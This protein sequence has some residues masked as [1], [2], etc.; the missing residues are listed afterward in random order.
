MAVVAQAVLDEARVLLNDLGGAVYPDL[1]MWPLINK[2]YRELQNKLTAY[3]V[4]TTK[5]VSTVVVVPANTVRLADGALL[6]AD[7][8]EPIELKE[9]ASGV[10]TARWV[11]V[12]PADFEP[13]NLSPKT[14]LGYW[15]WREDEIKLAPSTTDRD[16][17]IRYTKAFGGV[18]GTNSPILVIN[19]TQWL[20]Q[21]T[22]AL[23]A[24]V[25]GHN[26]TRSNELLG[27]LAGLW[28]DLIGVAVKRKQSIPVRRRRTRFRVF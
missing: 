18:T 24:L 21:R 2:A 3:G 27:D 6:P 8:I 14:Y 28:S 22:A 5:E 25:I 17:L 26:V 1:P 11:V 4:G 19:S 15:A 9:R 12:S 7:L 16:L 20:A 13:D 23:A 10:T